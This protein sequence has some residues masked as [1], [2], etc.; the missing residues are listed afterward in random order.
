MLLFTKHEIM[1]EFI[2]GFTLPLN[3]ASEHLIEGNSTFL[4]VVDHAR[5][6]KGACPSRARDPPCRGQHHMRPIRSV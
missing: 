6:T 3:L 1:H 5:T 4:Q 2:R